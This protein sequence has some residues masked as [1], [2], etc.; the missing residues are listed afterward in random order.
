MAEVMVTVSTRVRDM[1][2][3]IR[4]RAQGQSMRMRMN[5]SI[6]VSYGEKA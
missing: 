4:A 5:M 2:T 1:S 3:I 6:N